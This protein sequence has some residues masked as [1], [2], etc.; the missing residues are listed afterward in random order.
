MMINRKKYI[1]KTY[2]RDVNKYQYN[3]FEDKENN[4]YI[5][6]KKIL[7]IK[8]PFCTEQGGCL[9]DNNYYIVEIVPL[10]ENY[11]IRIFIDNK[12]HTLLYYFDITKKNAF[13]K[14]VNSP[15][16]DDLY[17]DVV[18]KDGNI[19]VLDEDELKKALEERCIDKEEYDLAIHKKD[20]LIKSLKSNKNKFMKID[21]MKYL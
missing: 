17:L 12:K 9:I 7:E 14:Q 18:L 21:F 11:C 15:Y 2:L 5:S 20:E 10:N 3:F 6:I 16:Y 19:R 13:D 4:C 8:N 1:C